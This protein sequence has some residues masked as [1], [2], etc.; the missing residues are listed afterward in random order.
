MP[1]NGATQKAFINRLYQA[2]QLELDE[3]LDVF[4]K[5]KKQRNVDSLYAVLCP[6]ASEDEIVFIHKP[7]GQLTQL[8]KDVIANAEEYLMQL[9]ELA[10]KEMVLGESRAIT[11]K[12]EDVTDLGDGSYMIFRGRS[13][14]NVYGELA[15]SE[16]L[17]ER[18]RAFTNM[19]AQLFTARRYAELAALFAEP[20][21]AAYSA[22]QLQA[23]VEKAEQQYGTFDLF[24]GVEVASVYWGKGREKKYFDDQKL[25]A[26]ITRNQRA[27]SAK[28]QLLSAYTPNGVAHWEHTAFCNVMETEGGF[29]RLYELKLASTY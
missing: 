7:S 5:S 4:Y 8:S 11:P 25:P 20:V 13:N 29:L 12:A 3:S 14:Y 28:F 19:I 1:I 24:D 10:P 17:Y 23:M 26:G 16:L 2:K 15:R 27:G 9:G 18:L 6:Y 21:A 22:D